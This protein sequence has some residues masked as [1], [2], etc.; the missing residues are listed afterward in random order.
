MKRP[1]AEI[2]EDIRLLYRGTY[3]NVIYN[4]TKKIEELQKKAQKGGA[5]NQFEAMSQKKIKCDIC[6]SLMIPMYG[7]GWDNDRMCCIDRDCGAE[8][9]FPTST[10]VEETK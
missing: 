7:G 4:L 10:E 2:L 8:I 1:E 3:P 9:V 5:V 6:G